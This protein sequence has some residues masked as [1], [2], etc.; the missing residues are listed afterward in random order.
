L[1]V[2]YQGSSA[3]S[4]KAVMKYRVYPKSPDRV[5]DAPD[6]VDDFYLNLLDWS[7]GNVVAIALQDQV[8]L[9]TAHT[10]EI[11]RLPCDV[12]DR[13]VK[14]SNHTNHIHFWFER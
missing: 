4:N 13:L 10:A 14:S 1:K 3:V 8:Y 2:V 12:A 7:A 5:L 11:V 9:W 6:V